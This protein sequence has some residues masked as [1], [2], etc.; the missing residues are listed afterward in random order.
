MGEN[1]LNRKTAI[2]E[3][4]RA[5][6]ETMKNQSEPSSPAALESNDKDKDKDSLSFGR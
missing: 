4:D 1:E 6:S 2:K 3:K 5:T